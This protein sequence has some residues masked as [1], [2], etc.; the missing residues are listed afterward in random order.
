MRIYNIVSIY[1]EDGDVKEGS[2]FSLDLVGAI[3][4]AVGFDDPTRFLG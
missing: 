2:W 1:R 3:G 4:G